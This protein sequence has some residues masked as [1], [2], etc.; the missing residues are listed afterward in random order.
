MEKLENSMR[1]FQQGAESF[2]ADSPLAESLYIGHN[3]SI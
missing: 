2:F 1:G 3:E